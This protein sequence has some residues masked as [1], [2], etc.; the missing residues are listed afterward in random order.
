MK[1]TALT[2]IAALAAASLNSC[3]RTQ[4]TTNFEDAT[5]QAGNAAPDSVMEDDLKGIR[6]IVKIIVAIAAAAVIA[7]AA[8]GQAQAQGQGQHQGQILLP[9]LPH[10]RHGRTDRT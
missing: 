2:I 1:Y 4:T 8:G 6:N 5:E 3:K 9:D 7:A 10:A